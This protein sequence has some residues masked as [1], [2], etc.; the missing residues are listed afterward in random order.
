VAVGKD[1]KRLSKMVGLLALA[2]AWIHR[3]GELLHDGGSPIPLK[4]HFSGRSSP[5]S[6][7]ASTS[8]A[9]SP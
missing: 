8:C 1:S 5:S 4:K 7:T 9:T 6:A 2:F 3:T